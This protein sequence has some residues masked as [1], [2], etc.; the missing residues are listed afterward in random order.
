MPKHNNKPESKT[1]P[2][3]IEYR[4]HGNTVSAWNETLAE[5][6]QFVVLQLDEFRIFI[7]LAKEFNIQCILLGDDED[8]QWD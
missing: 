8:S 4:I 1:L 7:K 6:G 5:Y 2:S 3:V